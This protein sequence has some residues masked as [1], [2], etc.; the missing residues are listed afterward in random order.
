VGRWGV[1]LLITAVLL[2]GLPDLA[3]HLGGRLG[4][5]PTVDAVSLVC[6]LAS[7][8]LAVLGYI[9]WVNGLAAREAARSEEAR[10]LNDVRRPA[11]PPAPA[12]AHD[13]TPGPGTF[14]PRQPQEPGA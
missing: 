8:G 4:T 10:T 2:S 6:M 3:A 12:A 1:V 9:A 11:R 5:L 14:R 13:A 7:V